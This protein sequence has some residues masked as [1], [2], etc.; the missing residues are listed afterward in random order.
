MPRSVEIPDVR[1]ILTRAMREIA[2]DINCV[3]VGTV[4]AFDATKQ[5]VTVTLNYKRV[6][7]D[8]LGNET[9]I[10]Y[11]PLIQCPVMVLTGGTGAITMPIAVGDT[12]IVLFA[13][14]DIDNWVQYGVTENTPN[15]QRVH[16][17]NDAIAIVG[18]NPLSKL[19][20]SYVTDGIKIFLGDNYILIDANKIKLIKGNNI[21]KIENKI[22]LSVGGQTLVAAIDSLCTALT[23]WVDTHGDSPNGGTIAAINAAKAEVDAVLE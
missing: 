1:E 20:K 14:R 13:D 21:V 19:I 6:V 3:S 10:A 18:I 17:M 2:L 16:D 23:S 7:R 12:C 5:M 11:Q 22:S 15:S 4:Q 9:P 8:N